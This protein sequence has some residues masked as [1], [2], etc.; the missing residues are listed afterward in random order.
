MSWLI[1]LATLYLLWIFYLAVMALWRAKRDGS[2]SRPALWL[3]YPI[4]VVGAMLDVL[5]NLTIMTLLFAEIPQHWLVTSRLQQHINFGSGW[6][7]KLATWICSSL[8][9][10]FDPTG[11]HCD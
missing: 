5:V 9:D 6:R 7:Q 4:L 10:S 2:I 3:G 1:A 8:L 11:L